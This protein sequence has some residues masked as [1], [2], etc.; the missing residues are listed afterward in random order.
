MVNAA[1][2]VWSSLAQQAATDANNSAAGATIKPSTADSFQ[3]FKKQ[4]KENAKKVCN[5]N[6]CTYKLLF[7]IY[8]I[9][10]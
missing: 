4:A 5:Y 6:K 7:V 2:N 10:I 3:Q 9:L 8:I 1:T